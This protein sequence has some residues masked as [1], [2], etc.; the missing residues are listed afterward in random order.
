MVNSL[1]YLVVFNH[2]YRLSF[3]IVSTRCVFGASSVQIEDLLFGFVQCLSC[4]LPLLHP[5]PWKNYYGTSSCLSLLLSIPRLGSHW[6][7]TLLLLHSLPSPPLRPTLIPISHLCSLLFHY[8]LFNHLSTQVL[9]ILYQ[10][11]QPLRSLLHSLLK[12]HPHN[13][14]NLSPLSN[15]LCSTSSKVTLFMANT[16]LFSLFHLVSLSLYIHFLPN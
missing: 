7:L 10:I 9:P 1:L 4:V 15:T 2:S 5:C 11:N 13:H 16:Y 12:N 8:C 3:S 14:S 6:L